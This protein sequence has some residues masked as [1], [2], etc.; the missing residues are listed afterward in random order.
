MTP[1]DQSSPPQPEPARSDAV[2]TL[3]DAWP[4]AALLFDP[5]SGS[6]ISANR[7][8][9]KLFPLLPVK[10]DGTMPAVRTLREIARTGCD[11]AKAL[12]LV[13]WTAQGLEALAC[14]VTRLIGPEA[15]PLLLVRARPAGDRHAHAPHQPAP[16]APRSDAE[17]MRDIADKI[18]DGQKRIIAPPSAALPQQESPP[19][20]SPTPP[21]AAPPDTTTSGIDLAK[22]AHELKTPVSA[23]AA[24]SEIMT[25]GRFGPIENERYAGYIEGIHASA[26]HA[27]ELIERMLD[28]RS[29]PAS[30]RAPVLKFEAVDLGQFV[31]ECVKSVQPLASSKGV[32][33][34]SRASAQPAAASATVQADRTALKQIVLN[35]LTNAIKFTPSGGNITVATV[36]RRRGAA[37]FTVEDT[38]PGMSAVAIAEALRPVPLDV[39]NTMRDG[40]G[41]G[42]GLPMSRA[43]AEAHGAVLSIDSAPGRGT[44]VTVSFPGGPLL[45]I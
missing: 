26:R 25:E 33:L 42:L 13:F 11:E 24:A 1:T 27:L 7:A 19:P 8:G 17:S 22:L 41:L 12:S 23:I 9:E 3:L 18:R 4:D 37:A 45:A 38:G 10:L 30:P 28:R 43:L 29:T 31:A 34:S 44:R 40:G 2:R 32:T 21:D 5:R 6:L 16:H 15:E 20:A 35:L 39:P 36:A 14:D